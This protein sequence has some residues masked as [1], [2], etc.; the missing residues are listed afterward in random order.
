MTKIAIIIP[1]YNRPSYLKRVLGYYSGCKINYKIIITDSSSSGNKKQNKEIIKHF[2][3]LNILHFSAYPI[4]I[5]PNRKIFYALDHIKSRYCVICADDDFITPNGISQS[6]DFLENHPDF[7]VAQGH[8]INFLLKTKRRKP[9]F[10]WMS[11]YHL[12]ESNIFGGPEKRLFK[13]LANYSITTFYGVHRTDFLKMIFRE[14]LKFTDDSNFG[15]LL[16]SMLTSI[17]GKMKCLDIL[18]AAREKIP[19]SGGQTSKNMYDFIKEGSYNE[20][21]NKFKNCLAAH[22]SKQSQLNIEESKKIIDNAMSEYLKRCAPN[23]FRHFLRDKVKDIFEFLN[24]PYNLYEK[25]RITYSKLAENSLGWRDDLPVE[26]YED[27]NR[28][29]VQVLSQKNYV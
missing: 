16:L 8:Y 3:D 27:F 15:E 14:S 11:A 17:Y 20:K 10:Y 6:V 18:Y 29:R 24:L 22:L 12:S 7:T 5:D 19:N 21:Y 2:P 9:R 13:H 28:I 4:N 25:M 1:T 23:D 26:Y